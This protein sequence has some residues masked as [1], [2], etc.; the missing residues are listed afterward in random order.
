MGAAQVKIGSRGTRKLVCVGRNYAD[1]AQELGGEVPKAPLLFLKHGT[2]VIT[3]PDKIHI[4][5]DMGP[6]HYEVE[7]AVFMEKDCKNATPA[8]AIKKVAGYGVAIDLTARAVQEAEKKRG[9]PWVMS[10]AQDGFA[11]I[12]PVLIPPHHIDLDDTELWLQVDGVDKQRGNTKDMVFKVDTLLSYISSLMT[13]QA[14]DII[15]TGT[16]AGVGPISAGQKVTIGLKSSKGGEATATFE[17]EE[18]PK[19]PEGVVTFPVEL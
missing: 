1:H 6:I 16:P 17:V 13:L 12:A 14:G 2:S 18:R 10:K 8:H 5:T 4:P 15:L 7:L 9:E 11:P 3:P 19:P